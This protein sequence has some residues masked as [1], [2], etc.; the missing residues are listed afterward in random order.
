M[1]ILYSLKGLTSCFATTLHHSLSFLFLFFFLIFWRSLHQPFYFFF[2]FSLAFL[3]FLLKKKKRGS[4]AQKPKKLKKKKLPSGLRW[5]K[6]KRTRGGLWLC[7]SSMAKQVMASL[8]K[9]IFFK[10]VVPFLKK[11]S[12]NKQC[13]TP[14]FFFLKS[15]QHIY[16]DIYICWAS[17]VHREG[18]PTHTHTYKCVCVWRGV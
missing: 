12:K 18:P 9:Y 13:T 11:K 8:K 14:F 1:Q 4:L 6:E 5:A 16:I 10:C 15:P 7:V 3:G 17:A 2:T